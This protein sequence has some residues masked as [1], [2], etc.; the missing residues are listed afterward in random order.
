VSAAR[1]AKS[2]GRSSPRRRRVVV[3][4]GPT[5]E[6]VDA[7][8]YL[9]NESSGAMGFEIARAAAAQ[10][11]HVVLITG[12]VELDTPPGVTRVDVVTAREMHAAVRDAFRTADALFMAAAVSDWRPRRRRV[13]KWRKERGVET[14]T[15]ELVKNPDILADACRTKGH[16]LV[17][18]FAL[19][20]ADG[21]RRAQTKLAAKGADYVVLNDASA[22][23][24]ARTTVDVLGADGSRRRIEDQTKRAVGRALVRLPRLG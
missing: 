3:T 18:G 19:E 15:I 20:T 17:V 9:T 22:L 2:R 24:A 23:G 21:L 7:V 5:R 10:G 6:H 4:A 12:P 11:D 1:R 8:R 16:R 13:G 14:A